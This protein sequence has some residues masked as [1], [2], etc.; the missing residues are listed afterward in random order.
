MAHFLCT[1]FTL[2]PPQRASDDISVPYAP[3]L[4]HA[5]RVVGPSRSKPIYYLPYK[6]TIRQEDQIEDQIAAVKKQIRVERDKWDDHKGAKVDGLQEARRKR[7]E[8][9]GDIERAEREERQR[10]RREEEQR[11]ERRRS[12]KPAENGDKSDRRDND[13]DMRSVRSSES[14]TG[15]RAPRDDAEMDGKNDT[16]AS[17]QAEK[18]AAGPAIAVKGTAGHGNVTEASVAEEGVEETRMDVGDDVEY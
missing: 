12:D 3:R 7:D 17:A 16:S 4:P 18:D 15:E 2:P 14:P 5:Q 1:S 10:R 13:E 11:E 6:L 9:M 8:R